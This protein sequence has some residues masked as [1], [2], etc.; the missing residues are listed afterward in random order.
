MDFPNDVQIKFVC[1]EYKACVK[2][3]C[4]GYAHHLRDNIYC[5]LSDIEHLHSIKTNFYMYD[6]VCYGY[7]FVELVVIVNN[8]D[9][10]LFKEQIKKLSY[11]DSSFYA[12]HS[13]TLLNIIADSIEE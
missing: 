11:E 9:K 4:S 13:K 8:D 3:E 2:V 12:N 10:L 5:I 6:I 7:N 1:K